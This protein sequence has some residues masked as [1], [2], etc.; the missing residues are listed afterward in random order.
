M[1]TI[2]K[3]L[4]FLFLLAAVFFTS[5]SSDDD[6]GGGGT[7][8]AGTITAKIDGAS[9]TS[10]EQLT[11]AAVITAGPATTLTLQGS[12][13]DGKGFNFI[14]NGFDGVGTYEIGG[15]N[16]IFVIG[17]Y[18]EGNATDPLNT[19]TWTAPYDDES[20][21]GEISFSEVT[22]NN[23]KGTFQFTCKNPNDNTVKNITEGS[24]NVSY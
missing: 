6:N 18:V 11:L 10:S 21:R 20:G 7:A 1:K 15:T 24:F 12:N 2:K 14:V 17:S 16:S 13:F 23:V 4:P 5:C 3:S 8:G 22:D 9:F 19:Q